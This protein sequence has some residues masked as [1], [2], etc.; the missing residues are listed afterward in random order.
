MDMERKPP[1]GTGSSEP[2]SWRDD[3]VV[4]RNNRENRFL[5]ELQSRHGHYDNSIQYVQC[6]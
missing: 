5:N 4:D 6:S 2:S 1:D 3:F